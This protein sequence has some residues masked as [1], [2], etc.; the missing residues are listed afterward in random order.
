MNGRL[1][2]DRENG[3]GGAKGRPVAGETVRLQVETKRKTGTQEGGRIA[4]TTKE[5]R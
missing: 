4:T 1:R 2:N 3:E 5:G